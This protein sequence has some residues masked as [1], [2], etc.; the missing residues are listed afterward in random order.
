MYDVQV[1][2]LYVYREEFQPRE[3][4]RKQTERRQSVHIIYDLSD[5]LKVGQNQLKARQSRAK[6][7][8]LGLFEPKSGYDVSLANSRLQ[9]CVLYLFFSM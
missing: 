5:W 4:T 7:V 6:Q 9:G 1:Q 2:S 3:G 8:Y